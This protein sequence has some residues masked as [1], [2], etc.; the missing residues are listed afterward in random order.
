[1]SY[2]DR[3]PMARSRD[4]DLATFERH[5]AEL[6][7]LAYRMLGDFGRAQDAV[8]EAWL[9]WEGRR[10]EARSPSAYLVTMVTRLCLNELASAKTRREEARGDRLPEPVDL[11]AGGIGRLE[12][13]EEVSM[14]FLVILQRLTAV[15]RAVFLLHE[16]F[17]FSHRDIA[18]LVGKSEAACRKLLERAHRN[19]AAERHLLVGEPDER[20]APERL[21]GA[22]LQAAYA[23]DVDALTAMLAED[24]VLTADG[25]PSGTRIGGLRN[26][27]AP[28]HGPARI[29][30]FVAEATRRAGPLLEP[31]QRELNGQPA[32]VLFRD[33]S[34]FA[35]I[36]LRIVAGKIHRIFFHGDVGRL[37][38]IEP[39]SP[40]PSAPARRPS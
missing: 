32:I 7:A 13:L 20:A 8:Q 26:L 37:R 36:L 33:K 38:F 27:P 15:E 29:A 28:L 18:R 12:S 35:A 31:Q 6:V 1:M 30:A 10:E 9:R 24:A 39:P 34:P 40:R 14:A 4:E 17:D 3:G 22:F 23:G 16:V 25:G 2:I 19:V 5:R 11:E 21:L